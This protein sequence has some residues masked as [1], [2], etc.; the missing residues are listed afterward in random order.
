MHSLKREPTHPGEILKKDFL[1][2]LGLTQTRL[3]KELNT[4]FRTVNE[5]V[6]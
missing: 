2:P 1:K 4:A 5:I 3:A 6:R